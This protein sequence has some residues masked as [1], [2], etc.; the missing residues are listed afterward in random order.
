MMNFQMINKPHMS[1]KVMGKAKIGN[2]LIL[3][4]VILQLHKSKG[5]ED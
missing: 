3:K 4:K 5:L 2:I 1:S